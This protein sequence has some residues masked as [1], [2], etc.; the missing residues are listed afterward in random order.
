[1]LGED[2][3]KIPAKPL[4]KGVPFL[5]LCPN[6]RQASFSP[7]WKNGVFT[8]TSSQRAAYIH[9]HLGRYILRQI[10]SPCPCM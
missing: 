9:P 10:Q 5:L 1:M 2:L 8:V 7:A 6:V 4:L 3:N